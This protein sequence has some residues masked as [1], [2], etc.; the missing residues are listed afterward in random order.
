MAYMITGPLV[1]GLAGWG[2]DSWLGTIAFLP[3]GL[4]GG[5][6]ASVYLVYVR[7]VKS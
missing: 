6:A 4:I 1:Y 3:L 7:Y 2:L 5:G